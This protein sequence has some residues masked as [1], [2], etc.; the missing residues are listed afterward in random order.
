MKGIINCPD[1]VLI[2]DDQ[3]TMLT[4]YSKI[5]KDLG[6]AHIDTANT[7]TVGVRK[8]LTDCPNL[9]LL[10]IKMPGKSGLDVIDEIRA[11]DIEANIVMLTSVATRDTVIQ[12]L[13]KGA[14]NYLVK[15]DSV[16]E[17]K[18]RLEGIFNKLD[19]NRNYY[20]RKGRQS[21]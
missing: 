8:Y 2:I 16:S 10:D 5:L 21:A 3:S 11:I 4:I 9:V 1:R 17:I 19:F 14:K 12:C 20:Y 7:G 18:E 13:R 15:T 6:V